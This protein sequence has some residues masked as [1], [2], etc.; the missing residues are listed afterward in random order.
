MYDFYN[1]TILITG[2]TGTF[3]KAMVKKL[4]E[5]SYILP[6]KKPRK[7]IVFSRDEFKQYEMCMIFDQSI[8]RYFIGDVRDKERLMMAMKDVD[9]VFHAAAQKQVPAC[10]YNPFEAVKTNILGAQNVIQCAVEN[11]VEK[12]MFISTDKA[13]DPNN[14]YG[15]TK[16]VAEK[17]LVN[18]NIFG[19]TK[20][21]VTRYGNVF[22]SRGS[23]VDVFKK[24]VEEGTIL[25]T[26]KRMT[27]FWWTIDEAIDFVL[28]AFLIMKGGEIFVPIL[29][30]TYVMTLAE[31]IANGKTIKEIGK[32]AG[33]KI[34]EVLITT[35]EIERTYEFDDW[36]AYYIAPEHPLFKFF[37]HVNCSLVSLLNSYSSRDNVDGQF[38]REFIRDLLERS[39][40]C[41]Q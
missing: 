29:K 13:V 34:H 30:S 9:Y 11:D 14:L 19:N 37:H 8:M 38:E 10:E 40:K 7:I 4:L 36:G 2:G 23:V 17:L 27:R 26:D 5:L 25:I 6:G 39:K 24:Q 1:R 3:G 41:S 33:E 20:F 22:G 28:D 15:A 12:V 32:R 21:S 18:A 31:E 16:L 35:N